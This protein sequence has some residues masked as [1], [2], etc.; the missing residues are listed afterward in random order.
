MDGTNWWELIRNSESLHWPKRL[1]SNFPLDDMLRDEDVHWINEEKA[2][3]CFEK[4]EQQHEH[5]KIEKAMCVCTGTVWVY[6]V[7]VVVTVCRRQA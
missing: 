6:T 1:T 4:E 3:I 7:N 5:D 2:V